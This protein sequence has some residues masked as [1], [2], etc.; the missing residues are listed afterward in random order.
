MSPRRKVLSSM[1]DADA[2]DRAAE[3]ARWLMIADQDIAAARICLEGNLPAIA[4]YH[5]QQAIEKIAKG[6]LVAV[7]V[8]F[9]RRTTSPRSG[10]WSGHIFQ[11]L[12]R[13]SQFWP[14]SLYGALLIGIRPKKRRLLHRFPR[15]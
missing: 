8:P 4:A 2:D 6:L 14:R 13:R 12:R 7:A 15:M 9:P 10:P 5:C 3:V 11:R 1:S